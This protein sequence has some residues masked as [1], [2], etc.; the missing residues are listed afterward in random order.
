MRWAGASAWGGG[1]LAETALRQCWKPTMLALMTLTAV[2]ATAYG[3]SQPAPEKRILLEDVGYR[4]P[5]SRMLQ[6]SASL[7]TL[8]F[9]DNEHVLLTHSERKLIHREPDELPEDSPRLVRAAVIDVPEG[10]VIGE[11]VSERYEKTSRGK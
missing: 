10:K 3:S 9:I 8:N 11:T 6:Q 2:S 4:V 1:R 5:A 7:L